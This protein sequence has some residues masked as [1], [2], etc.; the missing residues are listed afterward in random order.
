MPFDFRKLLTETP[1]PQLKRDHDEM[2]W[3]YLGRRIYENIMDE[4]FVMAVVTSFLAAANP[5]AGIPPNRFAALR[6]RA[7]L[8]SGT[9]AQ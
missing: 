1:D 2:L 6:L 3:G 8:F 9:I 5:P 4:R 7:Y